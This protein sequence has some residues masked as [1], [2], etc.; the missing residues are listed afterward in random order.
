MD[1][2]IITAALTGAEVTREQQP[3]LP[4]TPDE[5]A[6]AAYEA[7]QAGASIVHVHARKADGT[8]T[9]D[10]EVY[11]EIKEKIAAKCNIIFQP[12]TGGAVW[13]TA[14]ERI[15]PALL[16]PEMA[17]LTAGTCNFGPD[18]F[19]NTQEYMES[20]A[21]VMMENGVKPEIE[22]FERGMID[23]ALRMVKKGLLKTPIHFDFVMG[24]P[25]AIMGEPRD[26][27][28][29]ANSIP[30]GSTW[31]VAGIGRF[32]LPLAVMAI[33]MGGHVRV[34]F[35]DNIFYTKGVVAESNAQLVARIARIAK[36]C[37]REVATP[38][39]ARQILGL[40][41]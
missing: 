9:Q 20:F 5:I 14:E 7:Y 16:K 8:P 29:L 31:T 18:V 41:K 32:E 30:E 25:G 12:S 22:I 40:V 23:N 37:G 6:E 13:H 38:D 33:V 19:M 39:E 34:G 11:R 21:K 24:V 15:Q 3:N 35:E 27:M 28:Y 26:L 17:S 2:L 10:K 1:K 4:I 36:E